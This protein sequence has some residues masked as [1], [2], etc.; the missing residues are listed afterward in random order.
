MLRFFEQIILVCIHGFRAE[1][2]RCSPVPVSLALGFMLADLS[3][4]SSSSVIE[5]GGARS[6]DAR[7]TSDCRA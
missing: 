1:R 7:S 6:N 3:R 5:Q 2:A 4:A